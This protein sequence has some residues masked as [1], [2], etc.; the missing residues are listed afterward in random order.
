MGYFSNGAEGM[1]YQERYCWNCVHWSNDAGCPVWNLHL[2][3]N[4]NEC[5]KPYSFLHSLIPQSEDHFRNLQ[6]RMFVQQGREIDGR[7]A[8]G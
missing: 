1:D 6:C 3:Y 2:E 8:A 4:Y 5:N 7:C